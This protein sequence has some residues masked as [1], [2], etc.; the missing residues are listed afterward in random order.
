MAVLLGV[1]KNTV[2][3]R[4]DGKSCV[5]AGALAFGRARQT[6]KKG[7]AGPLRAKLKARAAAAKQAKGR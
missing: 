3:K 5:P 1:E 4:R 2:G 6:T 7:H